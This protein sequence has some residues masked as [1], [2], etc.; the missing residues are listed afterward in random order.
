[1]SVSVQKLDEILA[2][3]RC[4]QLLI[5]GVRL[6]VFQA[7][8]SQRMPLEPL[9]QRVNCPV[10]SLRMVCDGLVAVGLLQKVDGSYANT[11]AGLECLTEGSPNERLSLIHH[12]AELYARW[13]FLDES[14]RR[15]GPV[16]DEW[17]HAG[18][19]TDEEAF[20]AAMQNVARMSARECAERLDLSG[21][22]HLVDAGSGPGTYA[23]EF[24]R[25]CPQLHCTLIDREETLT[26]ARTHVERAGLQERFSY[27]PMDLAADDFLLQAD[28][29]FLSNVVHMLSDAQCV[30]LVQRCASALKPGGRLCIKD[31][32]LDE[33]RT[34]PEWA[35]LF[36]LTMLVMTDGGDCYTL[37]RMKEWFAR[38]GLL[39][40]E[41]HSVGSQSYLVV[42]QRPS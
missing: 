24:A 25:A 16:P 8:G 3:Y 37:S 40:Q 6:G 33:E 41:T 4:S 28:V 10:R 19:T 12:H 21:C 5:A 13:G 35:A 38:A 27:Q 1:M 30:S 23:I 42:A 39:F 15:D 7:L 20:A 29:V 17:I 34:S 11:A 32:L 14:V 31:F 2:G 36:A 22:R 18:Y 26:V 9:A